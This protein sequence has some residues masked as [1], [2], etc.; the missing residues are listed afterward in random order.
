[1]PAHLRANLKRR[2]V[3]LRTRIGKENPVGE[4]G[5]AQHAGPDRDLGRRVEEVGHVPQL[6]RLLGQRGDQARGRR[7]RARSPRCR[8]RS[9]GRRCLRCHTASSPCHGRARRAPGHRSGGHSLVQA[10]SQRWLQYR[11]CRFSINLSD[12][13][14]G[15]SSRCRTGFDRTVLDLHASR[16]TM[17]P[18]PLASPAR[19]V[20]TA[21][22]HSA[23][24][25][26]Q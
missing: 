19:S 13:G 15:H 1:M 12:L 6:A 7:G 23:R 9:P 22:C 21:W 14:F 8:Q 16:T 2:L 3:G 5:L 24:H 26:L 10:G 17:V 25:R 4:A 11:S 18:S 20:I